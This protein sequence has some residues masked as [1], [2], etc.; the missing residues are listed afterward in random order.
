MPSWT[1]LVMLPLGGVV[2]YG[3][4]SFDRL[5]RMER[6]QNYAAWDQDGRPAGFLWRT[7]ECS[8]ISSYVARNRVSFRWLFR[9]PSWVSQSPAS[10]RALRH[11]RLAV[12]IWNVGVVLWAIIYFGLLHR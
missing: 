11:F 9:T 5:L 6:D 3:F 1:F 2:I 10:V 4:I 12:L 7:R 8:W